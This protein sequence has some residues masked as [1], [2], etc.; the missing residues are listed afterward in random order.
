MSMVWIDDFATWIVSGAVLIGAVT[1]AIKAGEPLGMEIVHC[2]GG[3]KKLHSI[4]L[5]NE[6]LSIITLPGLTVSFS[7]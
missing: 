7:R 5:Y 6:L 3:I 1:T 2:F 4:R